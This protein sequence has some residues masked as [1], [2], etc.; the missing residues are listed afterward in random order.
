MFPTKEMCD[1][2]LKKE[3]RSR[4]DEIARVIKDEI[5][6]SVMILWAKRDEVLSLPSDQMM[7]NSES[8]DCSRSGFQ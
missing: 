5:V 1:D 8:L 4:R 7:F 6:S 3:Q 2:K